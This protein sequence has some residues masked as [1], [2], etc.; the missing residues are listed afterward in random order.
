MLNEANMNILEEQI[1]SQIDSY[2]KSQNELSSYIDS[3]LSTYESIDLYLIN[4]EWLNQWKKYSCYEEIKFNL[5]LKNTKILKELRAKNNSDQIV[6]PNINNKSLFLIDSNSNNT[7]SK[8]DELN[9]KS[10]FHLITKEC[11]QKLSHNRGVDKEFKIG[12]GIF[13]GKLVTKYLDN[14]II[15]LKNKNKFNLFLLTFNNGEKELDIIYEALMGTDTIELLFNI[16]IDSDLEKQEIYNGKIT[17]INKS[18][19]NLKSEDE[20]LKKAISSLIELE[21]NFYQKIYANEINY[22]KMTLYLINEDWF[23]NFKKSLKYIEATHNSGMNQINQNSIINKMFETYNENPFCLQNEII[24]EENNIFY[25]LNENSSGNSIKLYSN[26]ILIT[27]DL[28]LN[29]I[30]LFRWN[31][32]IKLNSYIIKNN[33]II[34]YNEKDFE[35]FE[36]LKERKKANNLFFHIYDSTK[37]AQVINE[38]NIFG[39]KEYYQKYNIN[40]SQESQSYFK[41]IDSSNNN[42]CFGFAINIICAQSNIE[43]FSL[44]I[45]EQMGDNDLSIGYNSK[46][47]NESN[48]NNNI[49]INNNNININIQNNNFNDDI[50]QV[51]N[52]NDQFMNLNLNNMNKMDS[53]EMSY[54]QMMIN[55]NFK[56]PMNIQ[57]QEII[58]NNET[59]SNVNK[60]NNNFNNF[61]NNISDTNNP[62]LFP[63]NN[64]NFNIQ[65]QNLIDNN[66]NFNNPQNIGTVMNMN[67]NMMN[68]NNF[69]NQNNM[70]NMNNNNF[71]NNFPNNNNM[72]IN[73][74][75]NNINN[76]Q[77]IHNNFN[78]NLNNN[79]NININSCLNPNIP[80]SNSL[81]NNNINPNINF[82]QRA[83]S[84]DINLFMNHN[85][86]F[87]NMNNLNIIN[88]PF[89]KNDILKSIVL[90]LLNCDIITQNLA[91]FD[92]GQQNMPIIFSLNYIFKNNDY[93]LGLSNLKQNL[94]NASNNNFN[95]EEPS[96]VLLSIIVNLDNEISGNNLNQKQELT[97]YQN[98][99]DRDSMYK[100]FLDKIFNPYNNT[101]ISKNFFGVR[102]IMTKCKK[103]F[104]WNYDFE[105][106]KLL[107]FSV[108]EVNHF[109][110]NKLHGY[111]KEEN[112]QRFLEI[113]NNNSKKIIKINDCLDYYSNSINNFN[114]ITC[115]NCKQ[116]FDDVKG[117]N[118]LRKM[119]NYLFIVIK[120]TKD[121]SVTLKLEENLNLSK[122]SLNEKYELISA[123]IVSKENQNY[124]ALIKDKNNEN[125]K[126]HLDNNI[127]TINLS[128]A[129]VKGLPF[130]LIYTI[131]N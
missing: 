39:V 114:N 89:P 70:N 116:K 74:N 62:M 94:I 63:N 85:Q 93:N 95:L 44:L 7:I 1:F 124:Y 56:N 100:E 40:I 101:F 23:I 53:N 20:K 127:E 115:R 125:W 66:N 122:I 78:I 48:L 119:P 12:F 75:T 65:Q 87:N 102:E 36:L 98:P 97:F 51:H 13:D 21:S 6:L 33:I 67:T 129:N 108:K 106:F 130:L 34:I 37:V 123:I 109:I 107:E 82:Y 105:I 29:L 35:I 112:S 58:V 49:N 18:Y 19:S 118:V 22:S 50:N 80:R 64:I 128:D 38:M 61:Q 59:M 83:N 8:K 121:Y 86:N 99:N 81:K 47:E 15:L 54:T 24:N 41:L 69:G 2:Y 5:P 72:N 91:I 9:P 88:N 11:F 84:S 17:F 3:R 77:N 28:W 68:Y 117:K 46:N 126:L 14:I 16:G 103:C 52:L 4:D 92:Q 76:F 131:K 57:T 111:I 73:Q 55:E 10:N 43:E 30:Q 104:N 42:F 113:M 110:V 26:Y 60:L 31:N 32:Q 79:F 120:N 90:C 45:H 27:E 25:Y 96:N 71:N